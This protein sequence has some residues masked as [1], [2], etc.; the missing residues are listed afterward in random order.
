MWLALRQRPVLS[1]LVLGACALGAC[2]LI[3][4]GAAAA[5]D[6]KGPPRKINVG[7]SVTPPNV[8]HTTPYVAKALGLFAKRCIDANIIQFDGGQSPAAL[9]AVAQGTAIANVTDV[10]IGRGAHAVQIWGIAPRMPQSYT[11]SEGV[12]T[13]ADLKGK[14]LSAAGGGVGGYQWR[15][16]REALRKGNLVIDDAQFISQAT[17]GRLAGIVTGMI[18]GVSLHPEDAYL[19]IK[20]KPGAHVLFEISDLVPNFV[21]NVYGVN[22]DWLARDRA[23]L[24]DTIAAMIEADRV[25]YRDKDKVIPI[26]VEATQKP[27]EAVEYAWE[28]NTKNCIWGINEGFNAQRTQWTID[29]NVEVGDIDAAHKPTVAQ[30]FDLKFAKEAVEAAGGPVTIGNCTE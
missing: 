11:V 1:F 4:D 10:A 19:A 5:E 12:K 23:L 20:D 21:F 30:V 28:R 13:A 27:R 22:T 17:A 24:R 6:C 15:M 3:L 18:D 25:I 8:A 9:A 14:K 16:G 2:G 7:V 29:N 26:M